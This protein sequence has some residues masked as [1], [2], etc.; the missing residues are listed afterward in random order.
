MLI[1]FARYFNLDLERMQSPVTAEKYGWLSHK[2]IC[3]AG[4]QPRLKPFDST[5]FI[6]AARLGTGLYS[7]SFDS[8]TAPP[9]GFTLTLVGRNE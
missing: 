3:P 5:G 8:Q 6:R 2:S 1:D 4:F 9:G 7:Y